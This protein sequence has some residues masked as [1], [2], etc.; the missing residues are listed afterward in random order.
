MSRSACSQ[1]GRDLAREKLV[2]NGRLACLDCQ[3]QAEYGPVER[4]PPLEVPRKMPAAPLQTETLFEPPPR[5]LKQRR[6]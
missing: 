5:V 1:C 6:G 3:Y 2:I 4:Q